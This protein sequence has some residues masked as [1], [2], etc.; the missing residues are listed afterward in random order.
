MSAIS[1]VYFTAVVLLLISGAA[2][3][4]SSAVRTDSEG[5]L[6]YRLMERQPVDTLVANVAG[7][8]GAPSGARYVLIDNN[9]PA[10]T[11]FHVDE[12]GLLRTAAVIDRDALCPQR[13][14]CP[15]FLDVAVQ[16]GTD[17]DIAKLRVELVDLNDNAPTFPAPEAEFYLAE[18]TPPGVLFPLPVAADADGP[19]NGVVGYRMSPAQSDVFAVRVENATTPGGHVDVRLVLVGRLDRQRQDR[20]TFRLVAFDGGEPQLSGSVVI[21]V[22]ITDVR[23]YVQPRFD[24]SSYS[25]RLPENTRPGSRVIRLHASS[26]APGATIVYSFSRRTRRVL[27]NLFA[28]NATTGQVTLLSALVQPS[29]NLS[30]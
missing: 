27:G 9:D 8:S 26:P 20:Y 21:S 11:L 30:V 24:N 5:R 15:V 16:S 14:A 25:L 13:P 17:V 4:R 23:Q 7:D 29:Y 2:R 6:Y 18:S 1:G 22:V 28:I 19:P 3:H 10:V 12:L